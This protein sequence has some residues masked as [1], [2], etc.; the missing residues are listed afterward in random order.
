M[1][2]PKTVLVTGF[3]T[4][5]AREQLRLLVSGGDR[6][7]LLCRE[8][9]AADAQKFA[10][11][12]Q[13]TIP[14]GTMELVHGDIL[15]VDMGL[16]GAQIRRL[17]AEVQEVHHAAAISYLGVEWPLMQQVNVDGLREV[18]EVCLGMRKLER[19]CLWSTAFVAGD[20]VGTVRE[21]ELMVGQHFRNPYEASKAQAEQ[22]ARNAMAKLPI[23]IVR[24]SILVGDSHT[25]AVSRLDGPYTLVRA[26]LNAGQT[27]VPLP[28]RGSHP[29]HLVP[30]DYAA[31]AALF[32]TRHPEALGGTFHLV[33]PEPL[34]ARQFYDAVA[35]AARKPRPNVFLPEG[36]S[37]AVLNL[38]FVRNLARNER[39]FLDW[40]DTD[41]YFDNTR[42]RTL[43]HQGGI[44]C[45][46]V[47]TYVD[48]L[49]RYVRDRS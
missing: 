15:Q 33:D 36:L 47:P 5:V 9:F 21:D 29:L 32:L 48:A 40:F 46:A 7:L 44:E 4:D 49:V 38:P 11:D 1:T 10:D 13:A 17:H 37:R 2:R 19:V 22:L 41:V 28:G 6:V 3:P 45:P 14:R 26:I 27:P 24:P 31:R 23:T 16:T 18:L 30:V 12:L 42:A 39:S 35:D 34:T 20:R 8:K 25:G 43:L